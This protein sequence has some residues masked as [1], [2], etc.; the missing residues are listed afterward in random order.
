MRSERIA[1]VAK[2]DEDASRAELAVVRAKIEKKEEA[3][4]KFAAAKAALEAA[5]K[6]M[7]HA[8]R[9]RTRRSPAR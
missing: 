1:A 3:E 2:A 6:A 5:R 7:D 4:K 9:R 8:G